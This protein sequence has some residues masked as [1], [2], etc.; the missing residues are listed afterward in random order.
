[1]HVRDIMEEPVITCSTS[2]N[3]NHAAQLMWEHDFGSLPVVDASGRLAGIVTDRDICMGAY[4][5]GC[6]LAEIPVASVMTRHALACH[7]GDTVETAEELMREAQI[8]RLP[9]INDEGCPVGIVTINDLAR[10]AARDQ[11]SARDRDIVHTL[12]AIAA[13][14]VSSD[15]RATEEAAGL[16]TPAGWLIPGAS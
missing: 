15:R 16:E 6:T 4:T 1:M 5:Q 7:L 13:P 10:L 3:S 8:R 2:S 12:A 14:R 11:E 9:V